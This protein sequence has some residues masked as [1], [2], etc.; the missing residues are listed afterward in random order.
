MHSQGGGKPTGIGILNFGGLLSRG[1]F[2]FERRGNSID[3]TSAPKRDIYKAIFSGS[4]L[5]LPT[6]GT[7]RVFFEAPNGGLL[8][9]RIW[10]LAMLGPSRI[11]KIAREDNIRSQL[12]DGM[13]AEDRVEYM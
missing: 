7:C 12:A 4:A 5:G 3:V 10:G 1:N 13:G 8:Y 2:D 11:I 6:G 9:K